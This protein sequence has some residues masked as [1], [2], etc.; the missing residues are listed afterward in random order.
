MSSIFTT[1]RGTVSLV[2]N[3]WDPYK[4]YC[5]PTAVL[6]AHCRL[7]TGSEKY[8]VPRAE[9]ISICSYLKILFEDN[10]KRLIG[11]LYCSYTGPRVAWSGLKAPI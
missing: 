10:I 11:L 8:D 5:W 4:I 3:E 2:P 9:V 1:P 7:G 6:Q